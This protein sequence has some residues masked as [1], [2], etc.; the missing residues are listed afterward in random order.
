[1]KYTLTILLFL[2]CFSA[3]AQTDSNE[4]IE[5]SIEDVQ[6]ANE[7]VTEELEKLNKRLRK[8]LGKQYPDFTAYCPPLEGV[9]LG[10]GGIN[11]FN[12]HK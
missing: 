9:P 8:K 10:G 7:R 6:K 3:L 4:P 5:V 12:K 11:P 1:M 2:L